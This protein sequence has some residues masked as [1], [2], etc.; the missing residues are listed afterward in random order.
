MNNIFRALYLKSPHFK[1]ASRIKI[2]FLIKT[3]QKS[4]KIREIYL[5]QIDTPSPPSYTPKTLNL[6][7]KLRA[8]IYKFT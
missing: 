3:I 4:T 1:Y 6:F 8:N 7:Y 5:N 2:P